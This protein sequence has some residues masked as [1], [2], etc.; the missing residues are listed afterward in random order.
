MFSG[1]GHEVGSS[2][3]VYS[4]FCIKQE[5]F[6]AT[7]LSNTRPFHKTVQQNISVYFVLQTGELCV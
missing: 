5:N 2:Q 4:T 7:M 1:L 3:D 6:F